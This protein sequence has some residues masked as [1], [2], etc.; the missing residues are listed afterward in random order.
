LSKSAL[1]INKNNILGDVIMFDSTNNCTDAGASITACDDARNE[2]LRSINTF[3]G[4]MYSWSG[5]Y[6]F[7]CKNGYSK[8]KNAI[9]EADI[10]DK[11]TDSD[12]FFYAYTL[13]SSD[14]PYTYGS[15]ARELQPVCE[16][17]QKNLK[18]KL[19]RLFEDD[20]K[21]TGLISIEEG[22]H[23]GKRRC[24][25]IQPTDLLRAF[26]ETTFIGVKA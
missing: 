3:K 10:A 26:F 12:T 24:Y 15:L 22:I 18:A 25:Y 16:K 23:S 17:R 6:D 5:I 2:A 14:K 9:T 21:C 20:L 1:F 11:L 7:I 4:I 19:K 8:Q 13:Y